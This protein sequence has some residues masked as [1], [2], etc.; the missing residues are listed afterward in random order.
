MTSPAYPTVHG[1]L[2]LTEELAKH[3]V[4]LP[5]GHQVDTADIS[6]I[7]QLLS[8]LSANAEEIGRRWE[9]RA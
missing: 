9:A 6:G 7:A 3:F 2:S 4:V 8:F 1:D 5:S